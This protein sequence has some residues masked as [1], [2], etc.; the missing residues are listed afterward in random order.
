MYKTVLLGFTH[1]K[2]VNVV[3]KPSIR[4]A[5]PLSPLS[6]ENDLTLL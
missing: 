5:S 2:I 4:F 6:Y 1:R 3:I